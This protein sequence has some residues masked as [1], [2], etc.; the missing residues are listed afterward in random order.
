MTKISIKLFFLSFILSASF[1]FLA[2]FIYQFT[3]NY[4]FT[5]ALEKEPVKIEANLFSANISSNLNGF[6]K[7]PCEINKIK[8]KSYL[9]VLFDA[10]QIKSDRLLFQKQASQKLPIASLTKL[11]SALVVE[12]FFSLENGKIRISQQAVDQ[13]DT[14]GFLKTGEFLTKNE[15][16]KI[17]LVDSS[18]D[19]AFAL[20][21]PFSH[22]GFVGLMNLK[23]KEI[24]MQDSIFFNPSGLDP[25]DVKM[26]ENEINL[27][28]ANDL[29]LLLKE[30]IINN[31]NLVNVTS[32]K[33]A[34]LYLENGS[35]H[36]FLKNTNE[37]L[38]HP[39]VIGG[40]TGLTEKAGGCLIIALQTNQ[41]NEYII[42]VLLGSTNR[43]AEME[44]LNNCCLEEMSKNIN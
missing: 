41:P 13:L 34:P 27:S 19:G 40:K 7:K 12:E 31:P 9:S 43:F 21:E 22:Q 32:I 38:Q 6:E 4:F 39:Y 25:E 1:F 42:N 3:G 23:A 28:T 37:L 33:E 17:M 29:F 30:I 20:T 5:M 10:N 14:S 2:N 18:N 24:G 11:I 16:L 44:I 36:H 15:L 26:A 35:F 8:A